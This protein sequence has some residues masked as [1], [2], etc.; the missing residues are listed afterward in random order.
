MS[1]SEPTTIGQAV[2]VKDSS[3]RGLVRQYEQRF[4]SVLPSHIKPETWMNVTLGALKKGKLAAGDRHGR[5]EL[6]VAASNN[7]VAFMQSLTDA[8]RLGLEPGTEQYYLTPRKVKGRLEILGIVGYQGLVELIY[9]AGAVSSVI[10]ECVYSNDTFEYMPGRDERPIHTI[11]WDSPDRGQLRLAYGYCVMKDGATSKVVVLNRTDID[12]IKKSSQGSSGQYS[13]WVTNEPAMWLK[14]VAR[15]LSKWVPTSA[16]YIREQ[17][18]AVRDVNAET[19]ATASGAGDDDRS[20]FG[21][22]STP[23]VDENRSMGDIIDAEI[24]HEGDD[25]SLWD[26]EPPAEMRDDS[27]VG[28]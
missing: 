4:T 8:A 18:R 11:D 28:S 21:Q 6:E 24:V 5:T 22:P 26:S 19:A 20:D 9:R 3:P 12:R 25:D 10:V 23:D 1:S 14:S 2:A 27:E 13:P 7:V 15:Q 16:E 17:L